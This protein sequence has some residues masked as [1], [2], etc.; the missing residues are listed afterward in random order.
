MNYY[1]LFSYA[2]R[3]SPRMRL[4]GLYILHIFKRRY[5][6]IQIDPVL[7]CNYHCKMC[8]RSGSENKNNNH[9]FLK[10]EDIKRISKAFFPYALRLQVGCATEPTMKY[11]ESLMLINE[12]RQLGVKY[13]SMCT[14]G[15]LLNEERLKELISA[16][17]NEIIISCHGIR[18]NTYEYFMGGSYEAFLKLNNTLGQVKKEY[19][20]LSVR[21]NYTMNADNTA[22]LIDFWKVFDSEVVNTVQLRP[23]QNLGSVEYTNYDLTDI[24]KMMDIVIQPLRRQCIDKGIRILAPEKDDLKQFDDN[25][26]VELKINKRFQDFCLAYISPD[27]IYRSDFDINNDTY[28]S[29]ANRSK[30]AK[31]MFYSIFMSNKSVDAVKQTITKHLSYSIK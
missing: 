12:A 4:L 20:Q 21:I 30:F 28:R 16:G 7:A 1:K 26:Q 8:Y 23:I 15:V 31:Q 19:P 27:Y 5:L 22:E 13:I 3:M 2:L 6:N 9:H 18:K 29:Y 10:V 17:L 14:N 11:A 25:K 24:D